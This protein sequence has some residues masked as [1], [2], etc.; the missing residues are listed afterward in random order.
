MKSRN[1]EQRSISSKCD[2]PLPPRIIGTRHRLNYKRLNY[3]P[4]LTRFGPAGGVFG[5]TQT[6][7][8]SDTQYIN[9]DLATPR[10]Q[11]DLAGVST[12]VYV[13]NDDVWT[14][15]KPK[16]GTWE[17][18]HRLTSGIAADNAHDTRVRLNTAGDAV[19]AMS[20]RVRFLWPSDGRVRLGR[21]H[22]GSGRASRLAG[23]THRHHGFG[24]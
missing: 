13:A 15:D 1:A 10:V 22:G 23:S 19:V 2:R 24:G 4:T 21:R 16:R 14:A 20:A 6:V 12:V 7:R 9:L 18:M 8:S 11:I 3:T 17:F 5:P